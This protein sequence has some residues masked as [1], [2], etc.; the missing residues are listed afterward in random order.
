[1]K[2]IIFITALFASLSFAGAKPAGISAL[3]APQEPTQT[4]FPN[5]IEVGFVKKNLNMSTMYKDDYTVRFDPNTPTAT[6]LTWANRKLGI[7]LSGTIGSSSAA[8][9]GKKIKTSQQDY[10]FRYFRD[11][12]GFE[13]LYQDYKGFESTSDDTKTMALMSESEKNQS[14]L[15][16]QS[17]QGQFDWAF[18]GISSLELFGSSWEKPQQSGAGYYLIGNIAHSRI[19]SPTPF[20]PVGLTTTLGA[21]ATLTDIR[22]TTSSAGIGASYVQVWGKF[23]TA[24]LASFQIGPQYQE[25][26][27]ETDSRTSLK[28]VW[29]PHMKGVIGYDWGQFYTN[30]TLHLYSVR[31]ETDDTTTSIY[32]Q[33]TGINFGSRF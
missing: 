8:E 29:A 13:L 32:S 30:L 33:E 31:A 16:I 6:A 27:T 14:D 2:I 28:I 20:L 23:Y 12:V 21:D 1:M 26:E 25:F 15:R 3:K 7:S 11:T 19:S 24:G 22:L 4:S 9:E 17:Y 18:R 5:A 10:Q